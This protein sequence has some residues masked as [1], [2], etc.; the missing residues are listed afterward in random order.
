MQCKKVKFLK[1]RHSSLNNEE[2]LKRNEDTDTYLYLHKPMLVF[3]GT[4]FK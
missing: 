2:E 4:G 1:G 3:V